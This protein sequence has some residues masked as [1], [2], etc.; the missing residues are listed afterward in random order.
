MNGRQAVRVARLY[1]SEREGQVDA[2]TA[3]LREAGLRGVTVLRG[4]AGFGEHG[5]LSARLLDLSLDLPVVVEF[6]DAPEKVDAA[7]AAVADRVPPGHLVV[8]DA[9]T[10]L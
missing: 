8:W 3:S 9:S 7:L 4:I 6:F 2:L 10:N 1:L 5:V